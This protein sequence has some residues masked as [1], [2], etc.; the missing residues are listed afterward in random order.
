MLCIRIVMVHPCPSIVVHLLASSSTRGHPTALTLTKLQLARDL[1]PSK[2]LSLNKGFQPLKGQVAAVVLPS[3]PP[4]APRQYASKL[5]SLL[6]SAGSRPLWVPGVEICR[7][8]S[9]CHLE[10]VR[11]MTLQPP[12]GQ[13]SASAERASYCQPTQ[14][15][16]SVSDQQSGTGC[17]SRMLIA[18]PA[19]LWPSISLDCAPTCSMQLSVG[20]WCQPLFLLE[21]WC[22]GVPLEP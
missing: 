13:L 8:T 9:P 7:L 19:Y 6:V 5:I 12:G 17:N 1:Q 14:C 22:Y 3:A 10:Q 18:M 20:R 21:I 16:T 2:V 11:T 4:A 15:S